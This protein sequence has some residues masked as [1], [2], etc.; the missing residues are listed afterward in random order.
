M[1]KLGYD[2]DLIALDFTQPHLI[3]SH[4]LMSSV[5]YAACGTD[6]CM[7]MVRGKILYASGKY[8][9]IDL[10]ELMTIL[11]QHAMPTIFAEKE[12]GSHA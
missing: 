10:N 4:D 3:P 12:E 9:T 5:V 1:I 8:P 7:T 2:A 11:A 6:V